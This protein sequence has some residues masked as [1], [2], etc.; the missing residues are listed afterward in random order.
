MFF[1]WWRWNGRFEPQ[2][3]LEFNYGLHDWKR[4]FVAAY[5]KLDDEQ[6]KLSL[7]ALG[8]LFPA[9]TTQEL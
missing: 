4:P 2:R 7:S 9:P 6:A 5:H 8:V 3:W 1:V